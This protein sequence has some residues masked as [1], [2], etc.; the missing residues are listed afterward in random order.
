MKPFIKNCLRTESALFN[1]PVDAE[2][3]IYDMERLIHIQMG[4]QTESSEFTDALKKSIFYGKTL[5]V[6]NLREELG[7]LMWYMALAMD[8]LGTDFS[9]EADRVITK[10]KY[11][12]PEKFTMDKAENRNLKEERKL[13]EK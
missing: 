10:L 2:G 4:M 7:D 6:V 9:T 12:Y 8:E 1:N 5:D 11:R 3:K 13:L